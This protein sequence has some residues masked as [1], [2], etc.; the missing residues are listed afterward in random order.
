VP[1]FHFLAHTH[2]LHSLGYLLD[3]TLPAASNETTTK[4][5]KKLQKQK[6]NESKQ[7]V[8]HK[9]QL[10]VPAAIDKLRAKNGDPSKLTMKELNAIAL[11]KFG[12]ALSVQ[13]KHVRCTLMT[14]QCHTFCSQFLFTDL[15]DTISA[16]TDR[17]QLGSG[18]HKQPH[19]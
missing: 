14:S 7:V 18:R 5:I 13:K 12:Q 4:D 11:V 8:F 15:G 1:I 19:K 2:F 9:N 6:K 10:L 3:E 17:A 16:A